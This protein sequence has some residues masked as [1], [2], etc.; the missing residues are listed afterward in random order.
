MSFST[1]RTGLS[2][3]SKGFTLIEVA[4]ALAILGWVL[5]SAIFLVNQYSSERIKLR[6]N[7]LSNNVAWN[8]LMREY[9]S[10]TGM[11][12]LRNTGSDKEGVDTQGHQ[13]WR[14]QMDIESALGQDLYRYQVS[15]GP[16]EN[17]G[18]L[19]PS[20]SMFLVNSSTLR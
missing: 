19:S 8:Q 15:V 11:S 1:S 3:R 10:A 4:V 9:Q 20:L 7:F 5:G 18:E 17:A 16:D 12:S 13:Q 2:K 14:W 6:E